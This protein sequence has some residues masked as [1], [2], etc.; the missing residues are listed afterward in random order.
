MAESDPKS[1]GSNKTLA[2]VEEAFIFKL[3]KK[4]GGRRE[5][6]DAPAVE[7]FKFMDMA[8]DEDEREAD[9]KKAEMYLQFLITHFAQIPHGEESAER[10]MEREKFLGNLQPQSAKKEFKWSIPELNEPQKGDE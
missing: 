9:R 6:L 7:I 10:R 3:G 8:M 1:Y 4:L 5:I 2:T